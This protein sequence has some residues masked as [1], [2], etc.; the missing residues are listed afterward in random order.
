MA[1]YLQIQYQS[2]YSTQENHT[3]GVYFEHRRADK[4]GN[5][6]KNTRVVLPYIYRWAAKVFCRQQHYHR[7]AQKTDNRD[8]QHK[9]YVFRH[10]MLIITV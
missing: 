10:R 5:E 9:E 6:Q 4:C 1:L 8:A 3:Y 7:T 2:C